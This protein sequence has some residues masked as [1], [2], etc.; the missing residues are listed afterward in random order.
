[1]KWVVWLLL[2]LNILLFGYFSLPGGTPAGVTAGHEPIAPEKIVLLSPEAVQATVAA[3]SAE[4]CY[5][6]GSFAAENLERAR[7]ALLRLGAGF[8]IRQTAPQEA[9]RYWVYIPPRRSAQEAQAKAEELRAQGVSEVFIMQEPQWR[10]AISLGVFRDEQLAD[11]LLRELQAR[12]VQPVLKGT[13]NQAGLQSSFVIR[14]APPG[15]AEELDR[16]KPEFSGSEV[17]PLACQ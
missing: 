10:N 7:A 9:L 16:L 15:L 12:G 2:L 17:R 3:D 1:M 5:E 13:L 6:W 4:R 8:E 11:N 14:N